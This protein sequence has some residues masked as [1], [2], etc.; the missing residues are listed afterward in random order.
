LKR[1]LE[2]HTQEI[3]DVMPQKLAL[4]KDVQKNLKLKSNFN[5][6]MKVVNEPK[7]KLFA[8]QSTKLDNNQ[9]TMKTEVNLK[10][11]EL[12]EC[13]SDSS[14][15]V[16]EQMDRL[17]L[18]SLIQKERR[19]LQQQLIN[20]KYFPRLKTYFPSFPLI[21]LKHKLKSKCLIGS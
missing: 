11:D 1:R 3:C 2:Q 10:V 4:Q 5:S 18:A 14:R 21:C 7:L 12:L 15:K 19:H 17:A 8:S 20:L 13:E 9:K 16:T 6:L